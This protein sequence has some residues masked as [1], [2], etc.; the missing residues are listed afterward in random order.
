[1]YR[2]LNNKVRQKK[3][4]FN[5]D[6]IISAL[7]NPEEAH[8]MLQLMKTWDLIFPH[9]TLA[10]TWLAPQY[11]PEQHPMEN[12][13]NIAL[14]GLQENFIMVRAPLFHVRR[15]MRHLALRIGANES[16]EA[17]E[18]WKFGMLFAVAKDQQKIRIFIKSLPQESDSTHGQLMLCVEPGKN[19]TDIWKEWL[20]R[21]LLKSYVRHGGVRE[22]EVGQSEILLRE[23]A[24]SQHEL[25]LSLD[26]N[27][28]VSVEKLVLDAD[29]GFSAAITKDGGRVPMKN[30]T[31]LL[32][33]VEIEPPIPSIFISYAHADNSFR[34]ALETHL[35]PMNRLG[36]AMNWSDVQ[37]VPG[38][39]W[40]EAI[41]GQLR[42]ADVILLLLSPDALASD[43]IW[44]T[45]IPEAMIRHSQGRCRIVPVLLRP[46]DWT[47]M[48]FAK[49]EMTPKHPQ[50]NKLLAIS[51]WTD[52]DEAM[53]TVVEA[54]KAT[55]R[56]M[57]VQ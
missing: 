42:S 17:S 7:D 33:A 49:I 36:I 14:T 5:I 16:V 12:L 38:Q 4:V 35:E 56:E 46:C 37:I 32:R 44:K 34:E 39:E 45:E 20:V 1:M 15:M 55:L 30:F 26:G 11:L 3:G 22:L 21:E 23:I 41:L 47:E 29:A 51:S 9:P 54:V 43:Y 40:N 25:S 52:R 28:F 6:D 18:Y 27:Q 19:L 2:V 13:F 50:T 53:N 24:Q 57:S 48:P 10:Q 8:R 31:A